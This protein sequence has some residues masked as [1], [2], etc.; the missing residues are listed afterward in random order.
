MLLCTIPVLAHHS[1]AAE[2][3]RTK[4]IEL[5]GTVTNVEWLNPHI[6]FYMDVKDGS[7]K[8][9][10]WNF[11]LASANGLARAGWT[12]RM[13]N[14]DVLLVSGYRAKDGSNLVNAQWV[15]LPN[16]KRMNGM[17]P[18]DDPALR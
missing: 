17:S 7:G 18:V 5:K 15:T 13:K 11:Q 2:Y 6:H 8:V 3:D 12:Q 1:F 16:G 10:N 14:G 4:P 9:A